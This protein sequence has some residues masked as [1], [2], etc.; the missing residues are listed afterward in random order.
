ME[1]ITPAVVK[2]VKMDKADKEIGLIKEG[3]GEKGDIVLIMIESDPEKCFLKYVRSPGNEKIFLKKGD[4]LLSALSDRYAATLLKAKVPGKLKA[5]DT[6]DLIQQGGESGIIESSR[7]GFVNTKVKF[8]G[9]AGSNGKKM[10]MMNYAL[11]IHH[12][13]GKTN[14][15]IIVG[16]NMEAGKTTTTAKLCEAMTGLGKKI[17]CGKLTGIG[18]V[19]DTGEYE[20]AG[21]AKVL[22]I[23]DAGWP[24]TAGLSLDELEDAFKRIYGNLL[25]EKPDYILIE[26]ADGILQRET[27]M[28]LHSE[29][30]KKYS[31]AYI[32]ACNDSLGAYGGM[33]VLRDEHKIIPKSITGKGTMTE[34]GR[35]EI[36]NIT[37]IEAF[38]PIEQAILL[39]KDTEKAFN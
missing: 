12:E 18:S 28:L 7:K 2:N 23:I 6:I 34:L 21:A 3:N 27:A 8:L 10:N 32:L 19:Y 9:F 31:P 38:N 1:Y 5:G 37:G 16:T 26:I 30:L 4:V 35:E 29:F 24:S 39:A 15:V 20:K 13:E 14:L 11:P 36:K 25:L 17:C 22:G 33:V